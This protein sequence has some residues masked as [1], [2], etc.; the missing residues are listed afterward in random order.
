MK[1]ENSLVIEN[2]NL[3]KS[4]FLAKI[5]AEYISSNSRPGN[6]VMIRV[7]TDAFDPILRRPFAIL[8]SDPP[9]IWIYYEVIGKGTELLSRLKLNDRINILGPLGNSLPEFQNRKILMIAG[10]RGIAPVFYSTEKLSNKNSIFIIYGARTKDDLNLMEEIKSS[11]VKNCSFYTDD[12]SF[13]DKGFVTSDIKKITSDNNIDITFSCGPEE[14]LK[15]VQ[16][17]LKG[18]E[19]ENYVSLETIMGCGFGICH[20]CAVKMKNSKYKNVC[21]DGP[22]F[23]MEDIEW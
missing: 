18:M 22:I 1:D 6:F 19:T 13:G 3:S 10:G 17:E 20:S 21:T 14:M 9:H 23:K 15:N 16:I 2:I 8:R 4:F 12:G 7:Q 5:K 11:G